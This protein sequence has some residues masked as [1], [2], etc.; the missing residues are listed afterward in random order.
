MNIICVYRASC[1]S[2]NMEENDAAIMNA[3]A[4]RLQSG[5]H[6]VRRIQEDKLSDIGSIIPGKIYTM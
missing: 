3:V 1:F 4:D 2:P 6:V 5:G